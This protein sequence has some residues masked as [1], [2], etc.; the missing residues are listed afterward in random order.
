VAEEKAQG[1]Q[2]FWTSM[3]GTLTAVAAVITAAAGLL[4]TLKQSDK[5]AASPPEGHPRTRQIDSGSDAVTPPVRKSEAPPLGRANASDQAGASN[6]FD[7]VSVTPNVGSPLTVGRPVDLA[8][9]VHYKLAT[10]P[11]AVFGVYLEEYP[12]GD[13]TCS[14]NVHHTNGGKL[15]PVTSGSDAFQVTL[16]WRRN[17]GDTY[18]NGSP[19]DHGFLSVGSSLWQ[20]GTRREGTLIHAF[21]TSSVTCIPYG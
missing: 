10:A 21:G 2:G 6:S 12:P 9:A 7:V 5:T 15:V 13:S 14:G 17:A 1:S 11:Q 16:K 3:P 20:D 19:A 8:V 18:K 4:A